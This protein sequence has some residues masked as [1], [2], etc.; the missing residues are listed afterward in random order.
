MTEAPERD[1]NYGV[2]GK[3]TLPEEIRPC[4]EDRRLGVL[5][6]YTFIGINIFSYK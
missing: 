6:K 2:L 4:L 3:Y 1:M 5:E